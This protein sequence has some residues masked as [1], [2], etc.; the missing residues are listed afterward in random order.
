MK[1]IITVLSLFVGTFVF[2]QASEAKVRELIK[3]TGADK[4][5]VLAM[6]QYMDQFKERSPNVPDEFWND[7]AAEVSSDKMT[8]LYIPV[9]AKYYTES[10]I[11]ELIKFY[12][13]PVGQKTIKV[14]PMLM[15]D[16]IE[17]GGKMGMEIAAKV[18]ERLDKKAGYQ[19]PPPP[20]PEKDK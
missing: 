20:M 1:K 18:K 14:M 19:N 10:D 4:M 16:S 5:A 13:S 6:Q 15:K 9:Y 11:D 7:F 3:V 17:A 2:S 8:D 12:K